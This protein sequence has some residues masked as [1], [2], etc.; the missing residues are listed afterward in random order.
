MSKYRL[1]P[2]PRSIVYDGGVVGLP[3]QIRLIS[4]VELTDGL[5]SRFQEVLAKQN[6]TIDDTADFI[7]E[8]QIDEQLN[9][10]LRTS[11]DLSIHAGGILIRAV[12]KEA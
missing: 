10:S 1:Y 7:L 2:T 12:N 8:L 6:I 4:N 9:H 3:M 11:Y 5:L